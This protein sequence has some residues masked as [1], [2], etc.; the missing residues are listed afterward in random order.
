M[1]EPGLHLVI[2]GQSLGKS[3]IVETLVAQE[4]DDFRV[5]KV[6]M[7]LPPGSSNVLECLQEQ[8]RRTW[9]Q[10]N[11]PLWLQVGV[12]VLQAAVK[13]VGLATAKTDGVTGGQRSQLL[14][15]SAYPSRRTSLRP[16]L[17]L[18]VP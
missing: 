9:N 14:H 15:C 13:A 18:L 6:D 16:G 4:G 11:V 2:G 7:R 12:D 3:K 10:K 5:L 17:Q 8:A 1:E